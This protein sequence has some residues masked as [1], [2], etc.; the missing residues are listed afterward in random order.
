[1][2][3]HK[4]CRSGFTLV[5]LLVVI[6]ILAALAAL[7]F[8][9]FARERERVKQTS[10]ASNLKQLGTAFKLYAQDYDDYLPLGYLMEPDPT[11]PKT[12]DIQI[13]PYLKNAQVLMCPSDTFS[14]HVDVPGLGKQVYRS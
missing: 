3:T 6:A 10:C 8:P 11:W 12:W 9:V 1:M 4:D 2:D 13:Q 5:E 7:L 14:A